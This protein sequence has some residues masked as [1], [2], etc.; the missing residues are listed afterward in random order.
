MHFL[1]KLISRS[2]AIESYQVARAAEA[3]PWPATHGH[4]R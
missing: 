1:G 4:A 2:V 3:R